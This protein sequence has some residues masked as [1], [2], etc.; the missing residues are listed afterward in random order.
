MNYL[1]GKET[2]SATI[3]YAGGMWKPR[4]LKLNAFFNPYQP[5][6]SQINSNA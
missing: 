2:S 6:L 1:V 4:W 5:S 3:N